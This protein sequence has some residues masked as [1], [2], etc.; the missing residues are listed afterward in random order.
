MTIQEKFQRLDKY[1]MQ[2]GPFGT[3]PGTH[4]GLFFI[5]VDVS[6]P[7]LKVV[8]SPFDGEKEW[9]HVSVSLPNRCPTW[10][11]MCYIKDLFWD[12]TQTVVQFHPPKSEYINNH[13]YC[14]HLWR[15]T[16]VEIQTP[17]SILVGL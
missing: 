15:N 1:R 14:L 9:E 12:E 13:R 2:T 10:E 11:E 4:Y 8:C 3:A 7:P 17:P 6:K 16:K 5:K